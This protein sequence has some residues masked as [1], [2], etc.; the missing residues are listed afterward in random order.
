MKPVLSV[1]CITYNQEKY[2]GD[3]L[4][5]FLLQK[6]SFPIEILIGDDQ[7]LDSTRSIVEAAQSA[8][9]GLIHLVGSGSNV[10]AHRNFMRTLEAAQGKY[11][12]I[13]EGDDYWTDSDKLQIQVDLMEKDPSISMS[14]HPALQT[15]EGLDRKDILCNKYKSPLPSFDPDSVAIMGGGFFPTAS[16]VLRRDFLR[17]LPDW[18]DMS[19]AGDAALALWASMNGRI[20]YID[21]VMSVYRSNPGGITRSFKSLA[22]R[23]RFR[24]RYRLFKKDETFFKHLQTH[25]CISAAAADV[26][27]RYPQ[28]RLVSDSIKSK[29]FFAAKVFYARFR[30]SLELKQKAKL[31][32]KYLLTRLG[33]EL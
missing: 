18:F 2:I 30:N 13:C 14:F 23:R 16:V 9:P 5:G 8:H 12:A 29:Q 11:I 7:S 32:A 10:G 22:L 25:N 21:R 20:V 3:A 19:G 1:V 6:T 24:A 15:H 28:E 27:I 17:E 26:A 33:Y 31:F 4:R